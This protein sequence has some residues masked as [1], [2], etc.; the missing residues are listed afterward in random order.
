[1]GLPTNSAVE[2]VLATAG[3][4]CWTVQLIPQVWKTYRE[5]STDGLSPWLVLLW[6]L[7]GAPLGVYVIVQ[8]LNIP[9]IIQPQAFAALSILSWAQCQYYGRGCSLA[10]MI[11]AVKPSFDAG[12]KAGVEFFGI[13]SS[14]IISV[15]LIPQYFE[16]YQRGEVVGL[17]IPFMAVD[18][19][20][21]IFS[22]LSLVF[23]TKMDIIAAIT[24]GFWME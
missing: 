23:K 6:G 11:F 21:G 19:L 9:L 1:M 17:S 16:I 12:N 7:A 8:D 20:G 5:K 13:L 10:G 3:T 18:C 24:Y 14:V 15:A 2:N 22:V 4:I